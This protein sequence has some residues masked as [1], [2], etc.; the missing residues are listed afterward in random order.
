M[1]LTCIVLLTLTEGSSTTAE[2]LVLRRGGCNSLREKATVSLVRGSTHLK[3]H[4]QGR[5][6]CGGS[7]F[8]IKQQQVILMIACS[9]MQTMCRTKAHAH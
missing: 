4:L 9:F 8:C 5:K 3:E 7:K 6:T 1:H 2:S